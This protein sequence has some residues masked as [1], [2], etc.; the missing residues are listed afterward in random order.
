[1]AAYFHSNMDA[2]LWGEKQMFIGV[3]CS[4]S[5]WKSIRASLR[6]IC[7]VPRFFIMAPLQRWQHSHLSA[8]TFCTH[9]IWIKVIEWIDPS[10]L[11]SG[12]ALKR[13]STKQLFVCVLR[14]D[15]RGVDRICYCHR[16]SS[17]PSCWTNGGKRSA[18]CPPTSRT[19][20]RRRRILQMTGLATLRSGSFRPLSAIRSQIE[21]DTPVL[22]LMGT[23][24]GTFQWKYG[25]LSNYWI[26][27][28]LWSMLLCFLTY[29]HQCQWL[30]RKEGVFW[31]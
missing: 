27:C 26:F 9:Y 14:V 23:M 4:N 30:I 2:N 25:A 1:M 11:A 21:R 6:K 12:H 19:D 13:R 5:D 20:W 16:R 10:A 15:K 3:S 8:P 22:V 17:E 29:C 7:K 24:G 18:P 28:H 31:T